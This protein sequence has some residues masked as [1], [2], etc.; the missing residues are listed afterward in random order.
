MAGSKRVADFLGELASVPG[1]SLRFVSLTGLVVLALTIALFT[2]F[3]IHQLSLWLSLDPERAFHAAK[4]LVTAYATVWNTVANIWN[5]F[6]E[7]LLVAIPGWNSAAVYV[8]EPL[9]F[10]ALDVFSIA[11]TRSPYSGIITEESVPYQGFRCPM[12]G[13]LD[14]SS[15]WC[16][17]VAFYSQQLG[18]ASGS[19][20]SFISNSTI[21]LSTQTARRLSEMTGEPIVGALDLSQLMDALQS[22]LGA[23]IVLTG[24]LSDIVFH[25]A[26][27]ILSEAFEFVFNIV[28][29]SVKALSQLVMMAF[30]S[31][32]A[33]QVLNVGIDLLVVVI[34]DVMLPF[35]MRGIDAILC[36][37]DLTQVSGWAAQMSCIEQTCFQQ[38][39]DTF[40]ELF[41]T[42]SSVPSYARKAQQVLERLTN[43][44]TGQTFASSGPIGV[45]S[46]YAGS[47]E[48]PRAYVCAECFN[49]KIPE[50]RAVF[51]L[52]GTIY[53]CALDGQLYSGRVEN[54]CMMNGTGYLRL[55]GPRG[56]LT[57][58]MHDTEWRSTYT[59]HR[60]FHDT[61]LQH[62]A[63]KFE[64]LAIEQGGEGNS[65][66]VAHR[67]ASS[68]FNRDVG[69]GRDQAAAFIR[70]VCR[71]MRELSDTDG[72]PGT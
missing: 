36:L 17:K 69:L 51:L 20:S 71:Q 9:V 61:L 64:Q 19:T 33:K 44:L 16:G 32:L 42:F 37:F 41:H 63:G 50:L 57:N 22:L 35:F 60:E 67:L 28:I 54:A 11:F 59:L 65:G 23:L 53:G 1:K 8:V 14:R 6:S 21:V 70:G 7:V 29:L 10:T 43:K 4:G 55:C 47:A 26:W 27:S 39:S 72:G 12:D 5:G 52:V 46:V 56:D 15:E 48:T 62:Y 3:L 30:R 45:P 24:E 40:V 31:G 34:V 66:N 58:L 38:G 49:C 68:W 13:S 18:V 2:L 25:V